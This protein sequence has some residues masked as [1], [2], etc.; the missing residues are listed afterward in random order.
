M[1][2]VLD[3]LDNPLVFV[4]FL[5]MAL[6]GLSS[7]VTYLAKRYNQPGLATVVQHP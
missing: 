2:K 6:Y 3:E 7:V 5:L 1:P 4:V